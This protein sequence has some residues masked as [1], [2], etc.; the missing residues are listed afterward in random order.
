M[1]FT[2][3]GS[4]DGSEPIMQ[5]FVVAADNTIAVGTLCILASGLAAVATTDSAAFVGVAVSAG[6]AGDT[7]SVIINPHAIYSVEDNNARLAGATLDIATGARGVAASS[8]VDLV[9]TQ[10]SSATQPTLVSIAAGEHYLT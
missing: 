7:V 5:E 10:G 8:N 9:V 1:G 2:Y 4:F 3:H 6:G